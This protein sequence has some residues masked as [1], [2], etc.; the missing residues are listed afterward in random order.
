LWLG[1]CG[2]TDSDL[3][4]ICEL[5]KLDDL[6]LGGTG[7]TDAG[8]KLCA[9][10]SKLRALWLGETKVTDAGMIH[11]ARVTRLE[12]LSLTQTV[13]SD[14]GLNLLHICFWRENFLFLG[15]G[16][17]R[18]LRRLAGYCLQFLPAHIWLTF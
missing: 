3:H 2:V 14:D 18:F 4:S 8:L 1:E 13:V 17:N 16:G 9:R 7:V 15:L 11:L 10:I 6:Y 12:E 5:P